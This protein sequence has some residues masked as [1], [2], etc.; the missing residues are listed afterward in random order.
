VAQRGRR[1]AQKKLTDGETILC[2]DE[3]PYRYTPVTTQ[4]W[5]KEG[6][7]PEISPVRGDWRKISAISAV[8]LWLDDEKS[9]QTK[10]FF[11]L[12][13]TQNI[14]SHLI[15]DFLHQVRLQLDGQMTV[16]WDRSSSHTANRIER[17][18]ESYDRFDEIRI[19]TCCPE[20]NPCEGV[21]DW[22]KTADMGNVT[23]QTFD[24][25][26]SRTRSSLTKLQHRDHV[27]RWCYHQSEIELL[28]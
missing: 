1:T 22:S 6:S 18:F 12:H 13:P 9:L 24:D 11:R 8:A 10:V 7:Y 19:P 21:W 28:S 23:P 3:S 2:I 27:H 20:L 5:A 16:L 15:R 14:N 26:I 17:F 25:L 4:R